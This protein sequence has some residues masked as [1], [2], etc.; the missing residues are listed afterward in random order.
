[1][2]TFLIY[3]CIPGSNTKGLGDLGIFQKFEDQLSAFEIDSL[4]NAKHLKRIL[5]MQWSDIVSEEAFLRFHKIS[6]E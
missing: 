4:Q 2:D 5:K 3:F 1:M 6:T